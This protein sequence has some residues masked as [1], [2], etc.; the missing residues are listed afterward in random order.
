M[1]NMSDSWMCWKPR[2]LEPTKPMPSMNRSSPRSLTGMLKC[3]AWPGRST[4]RRSTIRTPAS[5]AS[6]R[7]SETV[8]VGAATPLGIRSS[9]VIAIVVLRALVQPAPKRAP[10]PREET[11]SVGWVAV[12]YRSRSLF[13]C[14]L[15]YAHGEHQ[16]DAQF[17]VGQVP[18]AAPF[19]TLDPVRDRVA[20][21]AEACGRIG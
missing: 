18:V 20:M 2:M 15:H 5:R 7:T 16:G 21:H 13:L 12:Q 1:S 9:V 8:V 4:K 10:A 19:E 6:E 17:G 14:I 11:V 3:W